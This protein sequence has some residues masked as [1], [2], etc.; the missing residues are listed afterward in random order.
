MTANK[1]HA[2]RKMLEQTSGSLPAIRKLE[3]WGSEVTID[4]AKL[5]E[6]AILLPRA[7][8]QESLRRLRE[9]ARYA[10][11]LPTAPVPAMTIQE[12]I[13]SNPL[14]A[15]QALRQMRTEPGEPEPLSPW[16]QIIDA[17]PQN[18]PELLKAVSLAGKKPLTDRDLLARRS[19]PKEPENYKPRRWG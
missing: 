16:Q 15:V 7:D 17:D 2:L 8:V 5:L 19:E 3:G 6:L 4:D 12:T 13:D 14:G 11:G 1:I 18:A 9:R 10:D